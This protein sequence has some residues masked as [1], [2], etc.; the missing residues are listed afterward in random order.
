MS[1]LVITSME[2]GVIRFVEGTETILSVEEIKAKLEAINI[3]INEFNK[4]YSNADQD[5]RDLAQKAIADKEAE[6]ALAKEN[7]DKELVDYKMTVEVKLGEDLAKLETDRVA[8]EANLE[9]DKE[10]AKKFEA[11]LANLSDEADEVEEVSNVAAVEEAPVE[12]AVEE[13]ATPVE[14]V[15]SEPV[16]EPVVEEAKP[17]EA[18]PVVGQAVDMPITRRIIF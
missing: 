13:V 5:L 2:N 16:V 7:L 11:I 1:K 10:E 12:E 15:V 4:N 6:I 3:K 14:E 8:D 17:A 9:A 18:V